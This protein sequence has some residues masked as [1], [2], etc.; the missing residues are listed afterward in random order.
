MARPYR[1]L[2][3]NN[4]NPHGRYLHREHRSKKNRKQA[5]ARHGRIEIYRAKKKRIHEETFNVES[6]WSRMKR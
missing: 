3:F 4:S 2:G 6:G 1:A 5:V